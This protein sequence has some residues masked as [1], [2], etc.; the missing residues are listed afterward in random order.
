MPF[1]KIVVANNIVSKMI[2]YIKFVDIQSAGRLF[3][4]ILL[5]FSDDYLTSIIHKPVESV[6]IEK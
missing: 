1:M 6:F 3:D 4:R 5:L 2:Y